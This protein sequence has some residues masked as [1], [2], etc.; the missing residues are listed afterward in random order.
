VI[1]DLHG[2]FLEVLRAGRPGLD[3]AAAARLSDGRIFSARQ[4]RDA[5]LVDEL[6]YLGDAVDE[7][8]RRAGLEESRV[9]A[10]RRPREWS[11]N[12]YSRADLP[13]PRLG[14]DASA[15]LAARLPEPG[16]FYL[17]WPGGP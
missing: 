8:E 3:A 7:L 1:D 2:R 14:L 6:G 10:Y 5:G 9:I 12:L 13:E 16:F 17:W 4:A 11:E 15:P